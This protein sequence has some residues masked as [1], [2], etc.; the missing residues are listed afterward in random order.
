M[1]ITHTQQTNRQQTNRQQIKPQKP[2]SVQ[3]NMADKSQASLLKRKLTKI[4]QTNEPVLLTGATGTGKTH[5]AARLH[6]LSRRHQFRFL[7]INMATMND[8]LIESELFGHEK[9]AFSGADQ[10][11]IGKLEFASGGTVLLDEIGEISGQM[12]CKLLEVLNSQT[13]TRVG[14]NQPIAVDVRFVAATNK[15]LLNQVQKGRFREDLYYRLNT[16]AFSLPGI[17]SD[18]DRPK[19]FALECIS[20]YC[21]RYNRVRPIVDERFWQ[22]I[23]RYHWPGNYREVRSAI[24][25][26]ITVCDSNLILPESLPDYIRGRL[27]LTA[28]GADD[29]KMPEPEVMSSVKTATDFPVNYAEFKSTVERDYLTEM[30]TRFG[31]KIN[32]TAREICMS[33]VTLIE[34][35]RRYQ[36]DVPAIR[37]K[38]YMTRTIN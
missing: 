14:G 30:L 23:V 11:R 36:I 20:E 38:N 5:L 6:A 22:A 28:P 33:K 9:G 18:P 26:A 27:I 1:Q 19:Q 16:F 31:G 17:A 10:R 7:S 25:H 37:A 4:A 8:N 12:Q 15:N 24:N 32:A 3:T 2:A 29:S 35:V 21:E 13:I 34:K